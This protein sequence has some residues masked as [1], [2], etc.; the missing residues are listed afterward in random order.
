M[1]AAPQTR[2]VP[3]RIL[4][5]VGWLTATLVIPRLHSLL[6]WLEHGGPF[7]RLRHVRFPASERVLPAFAL[8]RNAIFLV[9][10]VD[11]TQALY[12]LPADPLR[13]EHQFAALTPFGI[14]SGRLTTLR[15]VRMADWLLHHGGFIVIESCRLHATGAMAPG[16]NEPLVVVNAEHVIGV[17]DDMPAEPAPAPASKAPAS[18]SSAKAAPRSRR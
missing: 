16:K 1:T 15:N 12:E 14:L 5:T 3:V 11:P 4:T 10:P 13:V 18:A 7:V 2:Q 17:T 9:I 8:Q 6:D